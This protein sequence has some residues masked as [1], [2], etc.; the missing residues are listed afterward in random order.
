MCISLN[1]IVEKFKNTQDRIFNHD[2]TNSRGIKTLKVLHWIAVF[3][4]IA[5]QRQEG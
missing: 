1:L 2:M 3:R 5:K 4:G